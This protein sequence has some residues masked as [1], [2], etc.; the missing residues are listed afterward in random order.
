MTA[1]KTPAEITRELWVWWLCPAGHCKM[2]SQ[3]KKPCPVCGTAMEPTG[4]RPF[5]GV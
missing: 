4:E 1:K 2:I 3:Q 5:Q